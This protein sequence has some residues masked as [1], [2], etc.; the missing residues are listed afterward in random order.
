MVQP[1]KYFVCYFILGLGLHYF[2]RTAAGGDK[3]ENGKFIFGRR[4]KTTVIFFNFWELV[5]IKCLEFIYI[6]TILFRLNMY[7]NWFVVF[8]FFSNLVKA[9]STTF[10]Y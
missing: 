3:T 2:V 9:F 8:F 4:K 1:F 7:L 5:K 10:T 6:F